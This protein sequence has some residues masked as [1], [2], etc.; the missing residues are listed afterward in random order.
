MNYHHMIEPYLYGSLSPE[1]EVAFERQMSRDPSLAAA[2]G[3]RLNAQASLTGF[4][5]N[6]AHTR[7]TSA[8]SGTLLLLA[9]MAVVV[10]GLFYWKMRPAANR[11]G[12]EAQQTE[13]PVIQSKVLTD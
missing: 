4:S 5:G 1:D 8:G 10:L 2:A 12:E 13:V 11:Q 3:E 9:G 6:N 7:R